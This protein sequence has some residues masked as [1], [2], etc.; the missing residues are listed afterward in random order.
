MALE[1]GLTPLED[2]QLA[3]IIMWVPGGIIYAAAALWMLAVWIHGASRGG[4][5]EHRYHPV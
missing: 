3:G 2:Q 5:H 4:V 1:W